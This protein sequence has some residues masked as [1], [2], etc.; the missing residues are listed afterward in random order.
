[1]TMS[2]T[3][4]RCQVICNACKNSMVEHSKSIGFNHIMNFIIE[5]TSFK[6][7]GDTHVI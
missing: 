6:K 5:K 7:K 3:L 2:M 1:M 4:F